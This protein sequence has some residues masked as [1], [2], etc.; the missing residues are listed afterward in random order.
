MSKKMKLNL[1]KGLQEL[2]SRIQDI[3]FR[4][5]RNEGGWIEGKE[6]ALAQIRLIMALLE[7]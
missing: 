5:D 6:E 7:D 1:M 4:W 3:E 2:F